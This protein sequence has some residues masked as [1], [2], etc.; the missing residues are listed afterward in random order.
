MKKII[1]FTF[2]ISLIAYTTKAQN[3]GQGRNR[4]LCDGDIYQPGT[5][6]DNS[7]GGTLFSIRNCDYQ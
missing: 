2:Y 7:V 3:L 5:I 6:R 1:L 4:C